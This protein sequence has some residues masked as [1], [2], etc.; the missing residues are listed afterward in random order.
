MGYDVYITRRK[1]RSDGADISLDEWIAQLKSDPE[2]RLDN[3]AEA[4][5]PTG[6]P[7]HEV[8]FDYRRGRIVVKNPD[9]TI[10]RKMW[11]LAQKLSAKVEGDEGESY[12][13]NGHPIFTIG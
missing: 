7:G 1:Q 12:D 8:L 13:Q 9:E 4:V 6:D 11:S 3:V 10:L 5:A 2:M